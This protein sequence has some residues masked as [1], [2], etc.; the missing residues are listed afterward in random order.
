M[1]MMSFVSGAAFSLRSSHPLTE[2]TIPPWTW[3]PW[4]SPGAA[5]GHGWASH[6]SLPSTAHLPGGCG[7]GLVK[8]RGHHTASPS[9]PFQQRALHGHSSVHYSKPCKFKAIWETTNTGNSVQVKTWQT[10]KSIRK[11]LPFLE[12]AVSLYS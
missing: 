4:T 10:C 6:C 12:K 2:G 3:P 8:E 9:G 7:T 5:P 11:N 1:H